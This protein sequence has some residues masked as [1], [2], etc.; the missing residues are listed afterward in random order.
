MGALLFG[1]IGRI[2]YVYIFPYNYEAVFPFTRNTA[3]E[4]APESLS[5]G[6]WL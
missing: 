2:C 3:E 4:T 5:L 1:Q 6:R